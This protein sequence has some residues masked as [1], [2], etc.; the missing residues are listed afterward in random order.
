MCLTLFKPL[1]PGA[2]FASFAAQCHRVLLILVT[3]VLHLSGAA[4]RSALDLC[5]LF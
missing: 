2:L 3:T 1:S 4:V 5:E